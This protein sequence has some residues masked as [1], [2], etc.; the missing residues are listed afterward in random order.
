MALTLFFNRVIIIIELFNSIIMQ[1]Q[2]ILKIF[3]TGQ[4]TI[5]KSWREFFGVTTLKATLDEKKR[6]ID[7]KPIRLIELEETKWL[8]AEQ[9][10]EDLD[11]TDFSEGFK[12]DLLAGYKKSDFYQKTK[13]KWDT[14]LKN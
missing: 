3:G 12:K 13:N 7:V 11:K 6:K 1:K 5:P 4:I 2:V 14:G 8:P 9:L 10:K